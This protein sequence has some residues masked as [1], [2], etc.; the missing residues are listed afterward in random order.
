MG[1]EPQRFIVLRKRS[2]LVSCGGI[3]PGRF[4]SPSRS[5]RWRRRSARSPYRLE[6]HL[7]PPRPRADALMG[8]ETRPEGS[9]DYRP[10]RLFVIVLYLT[11]WSR[12]MPITGLRWPASTRRR[13]RPSRPS[14]PGPCSANDLNRARVFG[15]AVASRGNHLVHIGV[16]GLPGSGPAPGGFQEERPRFGALHALVS[17]ASRG[18]LSGLYALRVPGRA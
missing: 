17:A 15:V 13:R 1:S 3:R 10:P 16:V 2:R 7:R 6:P 18:D 12:R 8:G 4:R 14:P 9:R 5:K 11:A